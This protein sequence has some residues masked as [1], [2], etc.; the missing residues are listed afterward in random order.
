MVYYSVILMMQRY[1][2]NLIYASFYSII[3]WGLNI[4]NICVVTALT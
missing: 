2:E 1:E 4:F 3:W